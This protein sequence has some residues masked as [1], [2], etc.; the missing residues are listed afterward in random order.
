MFLGYD[1]TTNIIIIHGRVKLQIKD[2]RVKTLSRLIHSPNLVRH[3]ISIQK[4]DDVGVQ[5]MFEKYTFKMV[6]GSMVL[7]R[8]FWNGTLYKI[9]GITIIDECNNFFVLEGGD[10][11]DKTY[12]SFGGKTMLWH[13]RLGHI[14]EKGLHS[15]QGKDMVEGMTDCSL[16]FDFSEHCIYGK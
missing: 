16:N 14:G 5:T 1:S 12:H 8:I 3:L 7:A 4:M 6:R 2:E 15:L 11:E 10:K 13:Q 9:L